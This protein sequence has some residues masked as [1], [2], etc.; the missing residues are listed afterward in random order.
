LA[1]LNTE[2][3]MDF[4]KKQRGTSVR[5]LE[6]LDKLTPNLQAHF[7]TDL[8]HQ[9]MQE[10]MEDFVRLLNKII[11]EEAKPSDLAEFRV[12][13]RRLEKINLKMDMWFE[14]LKKLGG[15]HA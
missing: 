7:N 4:F 3:F 12:I 8:G 5:V 1:E 13:R 6:V 2:Q 11:E 9:L 14:N 10:D 15:K